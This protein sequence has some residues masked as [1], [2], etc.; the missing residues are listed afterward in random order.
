MLWEYKRMSGCRFKEKTIPNAKKLHKNGLFFLKCSCCRYVNAYQTLIK[1]GIHIKNMAIN[2][3]KWQKSWFLFFFSSHLQSSSEEQSKWVNKSQTRAYMSVFWCGDSHSSET[4]LLLNFNLVR[5]RRFV[6][7]AL[8]QR[9]GSKKNRSCYQAPL[10]KTCNLWDIIL[11]VLTCV[12]LLF[13]FL[14]FGGGH[15]LFSMC[16]ICLTSFVTTM[17]KRKT[18]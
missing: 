3:A 8:R 2:K 16:N 11:T 7:Q 13:F 4:L 9:W 18:Q 10:T 6:S 12:L 5:S 17:G 14:F 1:I 15:A